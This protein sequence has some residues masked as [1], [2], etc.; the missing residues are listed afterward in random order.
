MLFS[1][2][3]DQPTWLILLVLGT[4]LSLTGLLIHWASHHGPTRHFARSLAGVQGAFFTSISVLFA[5]FSGFLGNDVWERQRQAYRSVQ[6][7]RDSLL[8]IGTLSVATVSDMAPIREALRAYVEAVVSDE[9]PRMA[10]QEQSALAAQ[11]LGEVL[12]QVARPEISAEAGPAAHA[13]L[14]DLALRVR[15]ARNDRLT[16]SG[17]GYDGEKWATVLFLAVLTQVGIGLVQLDRLRPQAAALCAFTAAAVLT[18]GLLAA[19]KR[20][21]DGS[22]PIPPNALREVLL[23]VPAAP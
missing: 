4:G 15:T 19:R 1:L 16:I 17:A 12:R 5:L 2:W 9:W 20:P 8:A 21:F 3:L 14:L 13:A 6:A 22:H 11:A 23:A 10:D 7:E 18:L